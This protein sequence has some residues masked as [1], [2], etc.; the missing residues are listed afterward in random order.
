MLSPRVLGVT[1]LTTIRSR[2]H[3]K[4]SGEWN[5]GAY[6]VYNQTQP[7]RVRIDKKEDGSMVYNQ[8]G[9]F[10]FIPSLSYSITF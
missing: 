10:G 8:V 6:N 3:K 1:T 5:I 9:L 7:F 2:E 4:F